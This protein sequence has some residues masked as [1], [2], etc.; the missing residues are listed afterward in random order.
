MRKRAHVDVRDP[1]QR[2]QGEKIASPIGIKKLEA[3]DDQEDRGYLVAEAVFARKQV[4]E[5][6]LPYI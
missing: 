3:R 6:P 4:E 5:F 1:H 2:E